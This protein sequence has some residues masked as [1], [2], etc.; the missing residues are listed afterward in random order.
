MPLTGGNANA[1]TKYDSTLKGG[2]E[3]SVNTPLMG[4]NNTGDQSAPD[5][6]PYINNVNDVTLDYVDMNIVL[7]PII[8]LINPTSLLKNCIQKLQEHVV[9]EMPMSLAHCCIDFMSWNW[10]ICFGI[11]MLLPNTMSTIHSVAEIRR[12]CAPVHNRSPVVL[13]NLGNNTIE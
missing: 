10:D 3:N 12:V 9:V 1:K 4:G 11:N 7:E 2:N 5:D 8:E 6:S 13:I